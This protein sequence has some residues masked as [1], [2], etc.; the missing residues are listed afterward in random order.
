[1]LNSPSNPVGSIYNKEELLSIAKV[2]EGTKIIVLSDEMY[3]KLRYDGF[4]LQLLQV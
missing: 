2:L 4:E 3:E 1:M